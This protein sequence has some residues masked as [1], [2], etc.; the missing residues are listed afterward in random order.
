MPGA[1][2]VHPITSTGVTDAQNQIGGFLIVEAAELIAAAGLF[3]D[4]PHI[5]VFP[6]DSIDVIPVVTGPPEE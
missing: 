1:G 6:G 2:V 5:T 4:H 3:Q